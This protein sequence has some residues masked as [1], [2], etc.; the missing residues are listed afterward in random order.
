MN[1]RHDGLPAE[2][3]VLPDGV[4]CRHLPELKHGVET[5]L[6]IVRWLSPEGDMPETDYY[7]EAMLSYS[8]YDE[9]LCLIFT[10]D[11]VP[12]ATITVICDDAA[13]KGYLHMVV[14]KPEFRGRGLGHLMNAVAVSI[15]KKQGMETAWLT[16]DD[17]RLP[18]IRTYLK[19]GLTPDLESEP[20][21]RERWEKILEKLAK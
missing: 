12:A 10:V 4:G 7:Q 9:N 13:K 11:D 20:D 17:W 18:A 16:T 1:W 3:P 6:E 19:A 8:H 2:E 15:L 5:W 14:C 21:Y